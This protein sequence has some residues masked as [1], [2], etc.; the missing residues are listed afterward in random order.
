MNET[1]DSYTRTLRIANAVRSR[2]WKFHGGNLFMSPSGSL[3]DLS[4][5]DLNQLDR[6][7]AE[8]LFKA[9]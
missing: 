3:H 4:A 8:G 1:E 2:G 7:E 6:I 5:A 9:Q